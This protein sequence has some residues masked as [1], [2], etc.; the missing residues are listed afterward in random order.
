MVTIGLPVYKGEKWISEALESILRQTYSDWELIVTDDGSADKTIEIIQAFCQK[1]QVSNDRI[2]VVADGEHRG[3]AARLNQMVRMAQGKI[4][5]RM[6]ADDVMMP[7]RLEK[8]LKFLKEHP[9]A[10]VIGCAAVVIDKEGRECGVRDNLPEGEEYRRVERLIHPTLMGRTEWFLEHP[11]DERYSG[12]EDYELWLRVRK[13]ATLLQMAE[14]L[15]CYRDRMQYSISHCWR[16]RW[17]GIR[18]IW[19]ERHLFSSTPRAIAQILN[20]VFVMLSVPII[21]ILH[22]DKWVILRRNSNSIPHN[23]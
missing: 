11:Y 6:D 7:E 14:P 1:Y 2:R 20:N 23:L 5:A 4:F 16:E 10:D 21:H 17:T 22:L 12:C 9:E 13:E 18:L 19:N 3:I 8:Q 15:I